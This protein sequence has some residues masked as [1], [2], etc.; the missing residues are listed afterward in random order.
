[1]IL[2]KQLKTML[3]SITQNNSDLSHHWWKFK[4]WLWDV[5]L[6]E[7][8]DKLKLS[9]KFIIT[10]QLLKEDFNQFYLRL[11]NLKIQSEYI[12]STE[13]Y[14]TRLLKL[15][16]NLMNQ[17]DHKYSIIQHA[18]THADKLWQILNREKIHLELKKEKNKIQQCY[19]NFDQHHHDD[20]WLQDQSK[21]W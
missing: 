19:E 18:V 9:K 15:L 3:N 4:H 1:M 13:N 17:H 20:F 11:F 16:Q 2:N 12:I 14:C 5:V 7:D 8:S 21:N 6:H 10:C